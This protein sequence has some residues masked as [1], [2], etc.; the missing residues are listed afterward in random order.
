MRSSLMHSTGS[1]AEDDD[2]FIARANFN[3]VSDEIRHIIFDSF[4]SLDDNNLDDCFGLDIETVE[5]FEMYSVPNQQKIQKSSSNARRDRSESPPSLSISSSSSINSIASWVDESTK[6]KRPLSA[7]NLFFQLQRERLIAGTENTPITAEDVERV[8]I[9]RR[10]EDGLPVK[11]KRK[12]RKSHGKISFAELARVIANK[13][14]NLDPTSKN[15]LL[16]RAASEKARFLR[17]LEE[18]TKQNEIAEAILQH[19][20]HQQQVMEKTFSKKTQLSKGQANCQSV[21]G[22]RE[23]PCIVASTEFPDGC[24]V[25]LEHDAPACGG[26]NE[27][28]VDTVAFRNMS[29]GPSLSNVLLQYND[30]L[31]FWQRSCQS[32]EI[33]LYSLKHA[34]MQH[35]DSFL[36]HRQPLHNDHSRR[37][38]STQDIDTFNKLH[39]IAFSNGSTSL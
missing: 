11:P 37:I 21:L 7:Y 10:I 25:R 4:A 30:D 5:A 3:G 17:E 29:I 24:N 18:W 6:P 22:N 33:E 35:P 32:L 39:D 34:F 12:H 15:L 1:I 23:K 8:A 38:H 20:P 26:W 31:A 16:E 13:W 28:S 9:A 36:A 2:S 14:K 27:P 19:L